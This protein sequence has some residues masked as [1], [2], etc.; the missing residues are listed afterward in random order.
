ME[1]ASRE[2]TVHEFQPFF[3]KINF[4]VN[5]LFLFFLIT[6]ILSKDLQNSV[7]TSVPAD[8]SFPGGLWPVGWLF[9]FLMWTL[10]WKERDSSCRWL[11]HFIDWVQL[12]CSLPIDSWMA[13]WTDYF[14]D[15][16]SRRTQARALR[17]AVASYIKLSRLVSVFS[18]LGLG[19]LAVTEASPWEPCERE[20]YQM[21]AAFHTGTKCGF[22]VTVNTHSGWNHLLWIP[23]FSLLVQNKNWSP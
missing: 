6:L 20:A 4:T 8:H 10:M 17:P 1:N 5:S 3:N 16:R 2:E 15:F 18:S 21:T 9:W 13:S 22:L 11:S 7:L 19:K 12:S 14:V 23:V